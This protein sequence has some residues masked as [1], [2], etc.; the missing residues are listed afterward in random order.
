MHEQQA[1]SKTSTTGR[2][3]RPI[4]SSLQQRVTHHLKVQDFPRKPV[5]L[6]VMVAQ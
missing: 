1:E 2:N 5:R 3:V 4:A 6:D